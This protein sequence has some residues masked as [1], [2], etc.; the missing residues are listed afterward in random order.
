M[1]Y[2][3][4]AVFLP[5]SASPTTKRYI[6]LHVFSPSAR[7]PL[8]SVPPRLVVPL[9]LNALRLRRAAS[10]CA[11]PLTRLLHRHEGAA[12]FSF[13]TFTT[14][15]EYRAIDEFRPPPRTPQSHLVHKLRCCGPTPSFATL[16]TPPCPH[17]ACSSQ[18]GSSSYFCQRTKRRSRFLEQPH[19]LFHLV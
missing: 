9:V 3:R 7:S 16:D 4:R 12:R 5:V 10:A 15:P 1:T 6:S 11:T 17:R 18:F 19:C 8:V 13:V 2:Y 14:P